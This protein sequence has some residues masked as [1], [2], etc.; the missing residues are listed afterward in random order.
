MSG[1]IFESDD[2]LGCTRKDRKY[3][4]DVHA[5]WVDI[6]PEPVT[7]RT[8]VALVE[9]E[10]HLPVPTDLRYE[11]GEP[12]SVFMVFNADTDMTVEW[13][14]GRELLLA[15]EQRL[16]GVGDVQVWPSE[17]LDCALVYISFRSGRERFVVAASAEAIS[18]FLERTFEV[19]PLGCEESFLGIESVVTQLLNEA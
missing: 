6:H 12:Y 18:V 14:F 7:C 9:E 19:V 1:K 5:R 8:L 2:D 10:A 16:S 13:E 17:I 4:K 11:S 15:G 3:R